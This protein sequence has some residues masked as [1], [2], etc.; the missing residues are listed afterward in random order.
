MNPTRRATLLLALTAT[1]P[2]CGFQPVYRSASGEGPGPSADLAAIEVKPIYERP[3]QILRETLKARLASDTGV[4]RRYD[5][6]VTFTIAG[7]ALGVLNITSP[8]R[9]RL[10]GSANWVL[11][12][13]DG[14]QTKLL[15]GAERVMDGFDIINSQYFAI[16]LDNE[17]VQRR[18]AMLLADKITL[19][20][21]SWFHGHPQGV[22]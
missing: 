9:I 15:T 7:E 20:L 8:T 17:Q 21:A 2:G 4:P 16:D 22:V 12:A 3:G 19:R 11:T 5:L 18:M 14:K 6:L 10:V 1:L 13:R